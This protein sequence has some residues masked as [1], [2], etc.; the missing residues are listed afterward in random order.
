ME[1]D[2]NRLYRTGTGIHYYLHLVG[3]EPDRRSILLRS[4]TDQ[5]RHHGGVDNVFT[6]LD[7]HVEI[8]FYAIKDPVKGGT[9]I[10]PVP[11]IISND[12]AVPVPGL[13]KLLLREPGL[14]E[15]LE[16]S[17]VYAK[18]IGGAEQIRHHQHISGAQRPLVAVTIGRRKKDPH[19]R[20]YVGRIEILR[21]FLWSWQAGPL[22][23]GRLL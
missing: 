23:V 19:L 22:I 7:F 21:V 14:F 11:P 8:V 9:A 17:I 18:V 15:L 1:V 2:Q 12:V 6:D 5:T 3:S 13:P 4:K 16:Q 20:G 10:F